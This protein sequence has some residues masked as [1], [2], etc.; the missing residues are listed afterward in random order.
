MKRVVIEQSEDSDTE[1]VGSNSS[2]GNEEQ[3]DESHSENELSVGDENDASE[4]DVS[5]DEYESDKE[6]GAKNLAWADSVSKILK[7]KPKANKPLVLSKAKKLTEVKPKPKEAG[8]EVVL[9]DGNVKKEL[10]EEKPAESEKNTKTKK[11]RI[12]D[13]PGLRVKPNVLDKDRERVLAKIATRGVVQLFNAVRA[14]QKD[15]N[16]KLD[17]AGPLEVRKEKVM[18]SIDKNTF[19]DALMGKRSENVDEVL[20]KDIEAPYKKKKLADKEDADKKVWDVLRDNYMMDAKMKDWDK[21]LEIEE[22]I[23]TE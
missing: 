5:S 17:E 16:K 1:E 10:V 23:E 6:T 7:S 12:K 18:K 2:S 13:I 4:E 20:E 8:F 22:E 9:D 21:E 11:K 19:L 3:M 14:Q 15:I